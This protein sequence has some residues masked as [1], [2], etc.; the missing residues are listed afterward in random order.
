[1]SDHLHVRTAQLHHTKG[2]STL[3]KIAGEVLCWNRWCLFRNNLE[4]ENRI[5]SRPHWPATEIHVKLLS[6]ESVKISIIYS[7][8]QMLSKASGRGLLHQ[9]GNVGN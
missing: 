7:D 3:K 6:T 1:M 9:T 5:L 8:W 4:E 2:P